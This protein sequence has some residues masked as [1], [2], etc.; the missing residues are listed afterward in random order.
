MH[1]PVH[2]VIALESD[3]IRRA[4]G[5]KAR[6][7]ASS[8]RRFGKVLARVSPRARA[9]ARGI[10]AAH[11]IPPRADPGKDSPSLGRPAAASSRGR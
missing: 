8:R 9:A 2:L 5:E 4:E 3:R 10:R 11:G 7:T 1:A 6:T